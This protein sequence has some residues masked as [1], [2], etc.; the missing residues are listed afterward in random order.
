MNEDHILREAA[1]EAKQP[2]QRS[3]Q[4]FRS[5]SIL[6]LKNMNTTA[7]DHQKHMQV[8][9]YSTTSLLRLRDYVIDQLKD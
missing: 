3:G 9:P 2:I 7:C 5:F 1:P 4:I 6:G 8:K